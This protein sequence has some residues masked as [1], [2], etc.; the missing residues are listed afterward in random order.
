MPWSKIFK[1]NIFSVFGIPIIVDDKLYHDS[2]VYDLIDQLSENPPEKFKG[3]NIPKEDMRAFLTIVKEQ[4]VTF[5]PQADI[6]LKN[7]FVATTTI[8]KSKHLF[9]GTV[10]N[11]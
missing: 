1:I 4:I 6:M 5:D 2:V 10:Q 8:R 11:F 7:Y 9:Y 3:F